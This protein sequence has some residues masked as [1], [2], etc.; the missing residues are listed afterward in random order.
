[1]YKLL[2]LA[3]FTVA[4]GQ[5]HHGDLDSLIAHHHSFSTPPQP[6]NNVGDSGTTTGNNNLAS[7]GICE[8]LFQDLGIDPRKQ[9][10]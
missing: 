2:L 10:L 4:T 3:L 6:G 8:D 9:L 1:M 7:C 5:E